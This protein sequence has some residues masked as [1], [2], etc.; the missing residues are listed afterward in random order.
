MGGAGPPA[1]AHVDRYL[2]HNS[3][4]TR[5]EKG[6]KSPR[7][8]TDGAVLAHT[9]TDSE[10]PL[11]LVGQSVLTGLAAALAG[12]D[13]MSRHA[14]GPPL[15]LNGKSGALESVNE[16]GGAHDIDM[17]QEAQTLA[18]RRDEAKEGDHFGHAGCARNEIAAGLEHP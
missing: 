5:P 7:G 1:L 9:R 18:E 8:L 17:G 2:H 16:L 4:R 15:V 12:N 3:C 14:F 10:N 6:T 13:A 11:V